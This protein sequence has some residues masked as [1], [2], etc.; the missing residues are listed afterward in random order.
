[1]GRWQ[2]L[3][4]VVLGMGVLFAAALRSAM[5]QRTSNAAPGYPTNSA[6]T[7]PAPR[8]VAVDPTPEQSARIAALIDQLGAPTLRERDRAMSEL[9]E[10][11]AAAIKQVQAA[12]DHDD[13]E[14][15]HR[16]V[17]L[18]EV[19]NSGDS[20][21]FLAAR[22]LG[23]SITQLQEKLSASDPS[24]LL[25]LL[26]QNAGAGMGPVWA[27]VISSLA[28]QSQRFVAALA[29]RRAEGPEGY[30]AVLVR[31]A[32][33]PDM[34]RNAPRGQG[35]LAVVSL[36]P[37][38]LPEHAALTLASL[39]GF[40]KPMEEALAIE[41]ALYAAQGLR[42]L[43][44]AAA[45]A[46]SLTPENLKAVEALA[47][48][49]GRERVLP[50]IVMAMM[51]AATEGQLRA[52]RLGAIHELTLRETEQYGLLLARSGMAA[53]LRA[54]LEPGTPALEE[55]RVAL[56]ARSLAMCA[57]GTAAL[58]AFDTL[59]P[60]A[61]VAILD[62]WWFDPPEPEVLQPFLLARLKSAQPVVRAACAGLA[63]GY[64]APSTA[65]AL[66]EAALTLEDTAEAALKA[67]APMADLLEARDVTRLQERLA[68]AEPRLRQALIPVLVNSGQN[69]A[70]AALKVQWSAHLPGNE[71][72]LAVRLFGRR[73]HTA[74]GA[75]CAVSFLGAAWARQDLTL[76]L[77]HN[78]TLTD[79]Q[80]VQLLLTTSDESGFAL[81]QTLATDP[82]A[83]ASADALLALAIA[84]RDQELA[85]KVAELHSAG[86]DPRGPLLALALAISQTPVGDDFRTQTLKRGLES[87]DL[88]ALSTAVL[89]GC[90]GRVTRDD[91]LA[92]LAASPDKFAKLGSP[93]LLLAGELSPG[94]AKAFAHAVLFDNE[95]A[96]ALADPSLLLLLMHCEADVIELLFAGQDTPLPRTPI[97]LAVT[98]LMGRRDKAAEIVARVTVAKDGRDFELREW[99]RAW[100][101]LSPE[102]L[103][104]AVLNSI[105]PASGWYL[106]RQARLAGEG[107]V[108][109]LRQVLDR[110]S[111]D[112]QKLLPGG[113]ASFVNSGGR[114]DPA[115][116][117]SLSEAAYM[118]VDHQDQP[119]LWRP[120][121]QRWLSED[122]GD[123]FAFWWASRRGLARLEASSGRIVLAKLK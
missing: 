36:V 85:P 47:T 121:V 53:S 51:P 99:S 56:L 55:R 116:G 40:D 80:L 86:N 25:A 17:L 98:A 37:P 103:A 41:R 50:A 21:L 49:P 97:Q 93:R 32:R 28:P 102:P 23:L 30:G 43:Y 122:C 52:L 9:A 70:E 83:P 113:V 84:G 13:D 95:Q 69:Q 108:Y 4:L 2:T 11:G 65:A 15:G 48:R 105:G 88:Q 67:L 26:E 82:H 61:Q 109:A 74:L 38:G 27:R 81:L 46:A 20:E 64:R 18:L 75:L 44:E 91:L 107:Q 58:E 111:W 66:A 104:S 35:L 72:A 87:P 60:H 29:C 117:G 112:R 94:A 73:P 89:V 1:M 68:K 123:D 63:R 114:G 118:G 33:D 119:L 45:C 34:R 101:G 71:L 22:K 54:A 42:G 16:C 6:E 96:R 79:A 77:R 19:L 100:L 31:A 106:L 24:S 5:A 10:F 92:L 78:L 110:F 12:V 115:A 39:C 76:F 7:G 8:V 62:A 57:N 120:L 14:I 59:G 3:L 90:S